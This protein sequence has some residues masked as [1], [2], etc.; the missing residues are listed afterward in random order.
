MTPDVAIP[1]GLQ[2]VAL[3]VVMAFLVWVL[4]LVRSQ[5]LTLRDSLV[6]VITTLV[7]A[8]FVVFPNLLLAV[9][10]P[11]GIQVPSNAILGAAVLYLAV[12][13][14]VNTVASSVNAARVRRLSQEC[15][16]LRAE[17]ERLRGGSG[18]EAGP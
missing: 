15:A 6:W 4:R 5:R 1:R 10:R 2:A 13:V 16:L 8:L 17:L 18:P 11:L 9:T 7:A 12:N 14:L 3:L